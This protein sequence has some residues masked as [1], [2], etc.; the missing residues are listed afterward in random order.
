VPPTAPPR[1]TPDPA[2]SEVLVTAIAEAPD[3][4]APLL[5][6]LP[7]P[8][9]LNLMLDLAKGRRRSRPVVYAE[10]KRAYETRAIA[11][12][13][14][15]G[16]PVPRIAWARWRLT[17]AAFRLHQLRNA[18]ALLGGLKWP[19]DAVVAGG[20]LADD[21]PRHLR[22]ISDP[23]QVVDRAKRGVTLIITQIEEGHS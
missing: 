11:A 14:A 6:S 16:Y 13:R 10:A 17:Y 21:S 7:E 20:W 22:G 8:P 5:L 18:L 19:V 2:P 1:R 9:S 12:V 23:A 3:Q 15:R 4:Q